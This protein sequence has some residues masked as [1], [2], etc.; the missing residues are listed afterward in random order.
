MYVV[1]KSSGPNRLYGDDSDADGDADD[2]D[3]GDGAAA[4]DNGDKGMFAPSAICLK[5]M[6]G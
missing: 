5:P 1:Y 6:R 4:A 2:G 3:G